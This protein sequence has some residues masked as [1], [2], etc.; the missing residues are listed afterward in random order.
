[1]A[2]KRAKLA[3][4]RGMQLSLQEELGWEAELFG[5]LCET[6]DQSEEAS[7]FLEKRAPKFAGK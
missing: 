6:E 3:I 7:A 1:M 2:V 4:E 5:Q